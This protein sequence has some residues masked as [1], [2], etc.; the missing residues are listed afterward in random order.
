MLRVKSVVFFANGALRDILMVIVIF[1]LDGML[2]RKTH[3]WN[4]SYFET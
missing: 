2:Q 1:G 4:I 3:S